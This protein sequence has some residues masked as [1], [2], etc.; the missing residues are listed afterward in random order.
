[1]KNKFSFFFPCLPCLLNRHEK[2]TGRSPF[3][4]LHG[5]YIEFLLPEGILVTE[6]PMLPTLWPPSQHL[7]PQPLCSSASHTWLLHLSD[8]PGSLPTY[9][10]PPCWSF[11]L[12]TLPCSFH[13]L[14][15]PFRSQLKCYLLK[16]ALTTPY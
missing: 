3:E 6:G 14:F 13:N 10:P 2:S 1:M 15:S 8:L 9:G 16:E 12:N 11:Y 5:T 7:I 4:S